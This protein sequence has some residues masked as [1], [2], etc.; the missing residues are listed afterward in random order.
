MSE[1]VKKLINIAETLCEAIMGLP[2]GCDF[3]PYSDTQ[4]DG[5]CEFYETI[6]EIRLEMEE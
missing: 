4:D 1:N 3:R 6:H 5:D 2:C